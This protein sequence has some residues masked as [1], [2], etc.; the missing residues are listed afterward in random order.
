MQEAARGRSD[1]RLSQSA[2]RRCSPPSPTRALPA[3]DKIGISGGF[4]KV[5][6]KEGDAESVSLAVSGIDADK[7]TT[8]VSDNILKIGMKKGS[9]SNF[10]ATITIT[11]RSLREVANVILTVRVPIT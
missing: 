2:A 11:Y 3:F 8:E 7:I 5:I 1:A 4:D 9:W 10:K 6:L